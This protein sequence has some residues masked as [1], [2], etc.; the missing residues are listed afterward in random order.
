[1]RFQ[2][3]IPFFNSLLKS[4]VNKRIE[5]LQAFPNFVVDDLIEILYNVVLGNVDVSKHKKRLVKHKKVLLNIINLK[6]KKSR[7][8]IIY[9]QSGGFL[10]AL[11][12]LILGI[13]SNF[14]SE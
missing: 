12:P 10:G 13:A 14:L 9:N 7:R 5:I 3:S 6:N 4:S 11:I 8:G 2:R 1:M